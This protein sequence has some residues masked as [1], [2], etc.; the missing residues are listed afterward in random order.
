MSILQMILPCKILKK[1][2]LLGADTPC[3]NVLTV[4]MSL[5]HLDIVI[6]A[7]HSAQYLSIEVEK[8]HK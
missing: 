5:K 6:A 1:Y 3:I 7:Y 4:I 8:A 2:H